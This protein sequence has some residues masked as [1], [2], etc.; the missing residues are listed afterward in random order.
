MKTLI[1]LATAA[2]LALASPAFAAPQAPGAKAGDVWS[3]GKT[4]HCPATRYFGT[5]KV[6][7]YVSEAAAVKSGAK[8]ARGKTCAEVKAAATKAAPKKG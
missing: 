6:G 4:Y 7:A 3:N 8:G 5:T 1:A 2:A